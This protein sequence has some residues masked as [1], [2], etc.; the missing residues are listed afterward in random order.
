MFFAPGSIVSHLLRTKCRSAT[1]IEDLQGRC[2]DGAIVRG[3]RRGDC[4]GRKTRQD[5][6]R[7]K[8]Y[9]SIYQDVVQQPPS[10]KYKVEPGEVSTFSIVFLCAFQHCSWGTGGKLLCSDDGAILFLPTVGSQAAMVRR[11]KLD[12]TTV[13][14]QAALRLLRAA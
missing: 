4:K 10:P 5:Y 1:F 2:K 8:I 12:R 6:R 13:G 9:C 7:K 3:E 14:S 11:E